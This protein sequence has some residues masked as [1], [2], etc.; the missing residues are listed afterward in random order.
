MESLPCFTP[1][2]G[3]LHDAGLLNFCT[4]IC[5]WNEELILQ[6][7]RTLH[8]TGNYDDINSWAL[9]WMTENTHFK[10]PAYELLHVLPVSPPLE[11]ACLLY[12]EPELSDH[13]MQVLMK[14]LKSGQAPRK[15]IP[16]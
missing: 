8:I 11:G 6:F 5:D 14:L 15:K 16:H 3:V 13:F 10:A 1:V 4:N 12:H 7:Y 9:D 2:V